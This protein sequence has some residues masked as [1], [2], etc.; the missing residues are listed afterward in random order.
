[1]KI[2]SKRFRD[3]A[4]S[5]P[6]LLHMTR[7]QLELVAAVLYVTRLGVGSKYRQAA[8][9]LIDVVEEIFD[10]GFFEQASDAVNMHVSITEND[11]NT[12]VAQFDHKN[13]A[14]EV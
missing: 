5:G 4:G 11:G 10:G 13:V 12:V 8:S 6:Y 2:K 1:M 9:T 3:V 14:I 7:E